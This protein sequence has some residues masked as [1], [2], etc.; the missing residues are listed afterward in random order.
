MWNV[1][2]LSLASASTVSAP[3]APE[4]QPREFQ[5]QKDDAEFERRRK[6]AGNDVDKLWDVYKWCKEQKKDDKGRSVLR[7]LL[8]IDPNHEDAN[9]ALG[10]IKYDGKWFP[11]Q[12]KVDEYKKE[13]TAKQ[14][15]ADGLVDYK[16]QRVPPADVPFLEK[17][18][19]K[20]DD[21]NWVDGEEYK[22]KKDGWFKQD[23]VWVSP[24]EKENIDKGLWKV[25]DKWLT[26]DEANKAHSDLDNWWRI[27]SEHYWIYTTCERGVAIDKIKKNLDQAWDDIVRL[28]GFTPKQPPIV[29]VLRDTEQYNAY[30]AA[31]PD[32]GLASPDLTGMSSV[33]YTFFAETAGDP[34]K[35]DE[36]LQ[37]GVGYWDASSKEGN[38][39]GPHSVRAALALSCVDAL[40]PS[41]ATLEKAKKAKRVDRA[42][43]DN[44]YAEKKLP[45][46]YRLALVSYVER[47]YIDRLVPA[48]GNSRWAR[49]WSVQNLVS[50]GGLRPLKQLFE[51]KEEPKGTEEVPKLLNEL[52]LVMSFIADGKCDTVTEKWKAVQKA[53]QDGKDKAALAPL[54]DAL[55]Q[56]VIKQET[57]L[58]KFANI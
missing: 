53:I 26:L 7:Q 12:K 22:K 39:W 52:G 49:E 45:V 1:L 25:G 42:F 24:Q 28:T 18:M 11:S 19:V 15:K 36:L 33:R 20:D 44:Y 5:Q 13:Q 17:G 51:I 9:V 50:K 32:I 14:E 46:W 6:E 23:L 55:A 43:F 56:E 35:P 54:L 16:G 58:R 38:S 21:G 37:V 3:L 2:L 40:D 30:A 48:D 41:R 27:P 57:A 10:N 29:I 47:Y 8:K 34:M 31:D 4:A